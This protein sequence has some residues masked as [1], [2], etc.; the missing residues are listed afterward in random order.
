MHRVIE[1]GGAVVKRKH[2]RH[3][4][5][6]R[7]ARKARHVVDMPVG[8]IVEQAVAEPQ[9]PLD[10]EM[11]AEFADVVRVATRAFEGYDP[12]TALEATEAS[13]AAA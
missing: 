3:E 7:Y 6:A 10:A 1:R 2:G 12:A 9:Q 4:Y 13:G 11:L 8:V 5:D